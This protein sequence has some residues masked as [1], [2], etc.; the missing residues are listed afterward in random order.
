MTDRHT[1]L[2]G[3]RIH[4]SALVETDDVGTGTRVWAFAH[5]AP[6]SR[7]GHDCNLCDHTFVETGVV[8]GDRVTVKCGI[9]LWTGVTCE[10]DVFLGPNVVFTNDLFPRSGQH[11]EP[12]VPTLVRTGASL[13]AN[14]TIL[15]GTTIGRYA[16][17]GAGSVVTRSVSDYAL[18]V[19]NPARQRGWVSRYGRKLA[20]KNG[21]GV[22]PRSGLRY[23]IEGDLCAP[24]ERDR[25]RDA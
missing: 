14:C 8:L 6:G 18:V 16:M 1:Q 7:V 17:V 13:G 24:I 3:V 12:Y 15:A 11:L 5:L 19:G 2:P 10:D 25:E 22:C 4:P 23:R 9:Y 20:V 21:V